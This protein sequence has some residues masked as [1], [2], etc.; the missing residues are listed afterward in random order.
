MTPFGRRI[1]ELRAR[2]QVTQKQMAAE[3]GVSPAWL[4]SLENGKRGRP[5]WAFL[6]RVINYFN[7]IWDEADE[8]LELARISHPRIV[9]DTSSLSPEATELANL[10]AEHFGEIPARHVEKFLRELKA[11]LAE[12][13]SP[14]TN[15]DR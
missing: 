11:V 6:Q 15:D 3:L 9:V 1:R 14:G 10:L 12:V 8:L 5:N 13:N 7:V 2:K 4:S